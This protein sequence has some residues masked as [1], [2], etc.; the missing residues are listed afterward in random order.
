MAS[1]ADYQLGDRLR[2]EG[3]PDPVDF[4]WLTAEGAVVVLADGTERTVAPERLQ[5]MPSPP[6][7]A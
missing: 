5:P 6:R 4:L 1:V 2:L 7:S 3:E